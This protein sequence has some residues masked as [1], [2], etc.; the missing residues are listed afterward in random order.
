MT[1]IRK[2]AELWSIFSNLDAG[3]LDLTECFADSE[4]EYLYNIEIF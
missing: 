3:T 2:R 4:I 1:G